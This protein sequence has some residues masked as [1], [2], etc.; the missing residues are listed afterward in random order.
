MK[1]NF[2]LF[3]FALT[4]MLYAVNAKADENVPPSPTGT[5]KGRVTDT[6]KEVLPGAS[7][8]P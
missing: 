3:M 1:K 4:V 8:L 7:L 6:G 5:I 2:M